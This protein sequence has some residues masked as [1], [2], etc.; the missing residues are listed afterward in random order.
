MGRELR[1]ATLG[2]IGYG[3]ISRYLCELALAFG[4]R[5]V[6]ADPFATVTDCACTRP[7]SRPCSARPPHVVCLAPAQ[8]RHGAVDERRAFR[9]D[10][11]R[12]GVR[13]RGARRAGG[14]RRPC[15]PRSTAA[16]SA[17]AR[18]TSAW[19]PTRCPRRALAAHPLVIATPARGRPHARRDRAPV[20]RD[21]RPGRGAAAGA[22]PRRRRECRPM[23]RAWRVASRSNSRSRTD[24]PRARAGR[25]L[26]LPCPRLRRRLPRSPRARPSCRRRRP[27]PPIATC[28]ARSACRAW[29]WC[30][31]PVTAPT[32]AARWP[33]SSSSA[34][35]ARGVAVVEPGVDDEELQRL[36][37]G[38][39]RG[40]RFMM[41]RG[42][43]L[44]WDALTPLASRIAAL[45]WH[46]TLQL[47]GRTLPD[48]AALL[49]RLPH[50]AGDRPSR[51]VPRAG[52]RRRRGL[53]G[54]VPAARRRALL[55][56]AVG[57][58]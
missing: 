27:P 48:Y 41:L 14:T 51:Q 16:G 9:G 19:P 12:R 29:W 5:V 50:A 36:H 4:M 54:A 13:Q 10:A 34:T 55:D 3:Q 39:M 40:L 31:R 52:G 26:R 44:G 11:A 49:A 21:R 20:A 37:A 46:I 6:V 58:L 7:G 8:C 25:R 15:W 18:S 47:D 38:G 2:V 17:A 28:S 24:E 1:G 22:H 35:G 56:Q 30:S 53:R 43:V 23:P 42:G 33:R 45:G 57:A 32:T